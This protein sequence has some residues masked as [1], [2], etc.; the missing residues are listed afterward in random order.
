MRL[1]NSM[2]STITIPIAK[3]NEKMNAIPTGT[4]QIGRVIINQEIVNT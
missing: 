2:A 4:I 3:P 1:I